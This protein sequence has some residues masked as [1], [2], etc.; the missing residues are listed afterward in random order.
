MKGYDENGFFDKE[1]GEE[2]AALTEFSLEAVVRSV[3][4]RMIQGALEAEVT[5]LLQRLP[6]QRSSDAEEFRGYRNGYN[7][8]RNVTTAVG[9]IAI[10]QPRVSDVPEEAG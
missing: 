4:Q 10:R 1:I 3:A 5:E 2:S 6:G 8:A 9:A 7:K